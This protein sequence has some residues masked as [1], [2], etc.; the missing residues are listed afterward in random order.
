MGHFSLAQRSNLRNRRLGVRHPRLAVTSSV[1]PG[2][3]RSSRGLGVAAPLF[4]CFSG[5]GPF[6]I[7][8]ILVYSPIGF[9]PRPWAQITV[10]VWAM[11]RHLLSDI[12][13]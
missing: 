9:S 10:R 11:A 7:N 12:L 13:P 2:V 8:L 6:V 3:S 1:T 4:G 5:G